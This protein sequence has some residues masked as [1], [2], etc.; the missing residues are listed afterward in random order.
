MDLL[1]LVYEEEIWKNVAFVFILENE[2]HKGE[3]V[4][5][6]WIWEHSFV[7]GV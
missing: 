6:N 7:L 1:R 2:M 3:I 5:A 4:N